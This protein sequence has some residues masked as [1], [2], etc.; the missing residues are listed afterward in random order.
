[1][2][3]APFPHHYT[4]LKSMQ[5]HPTQTP[6]ICMMDGDTISDLEG[7][8]YK[9]PHAPGL[10]Q[11]YIVSAPFELVETFSTNPSSPHCK[12]HV[13]PPPPTLPF[14]SPS[15]PQIRMMDGDTTSDLE[16]GVYKGPHGDTPKAYI[17]SAPFELV[18][19]DKVGEQNTDA[20]PLGIRGQ[21]VIMGEYALAADNPQRLSVVFKSKWCWP[22]CGGLSWPVLP[23]PPSC[24]QPTKLVLTQI[25]C[26]VVQQSS[27]SQAVCCSPPAGACWWFFRRSS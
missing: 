22:K 23:P 21:H 12:L 8:V 14:L 4:P 15:Q 6:Q 24:N 17:V 18:E 5:P 16:G 13:V 25:G 19:A 10:H 9:G 2:M 7:G 1:M 26:L 3:S 20:T 27:N 11:A